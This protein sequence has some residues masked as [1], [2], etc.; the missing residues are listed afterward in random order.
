[1]RNSTELMDLPPVVLVDR[2]RMPERR[3][4]WR[5]GRRDLD[6]INRPPGVL[7]RLDQVGGSWLRPWFSGRYKH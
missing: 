3:T 6:W 1:M 5:G 7:S 4:T 2:R